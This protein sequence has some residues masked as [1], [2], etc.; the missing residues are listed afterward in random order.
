MLLAAVICVLLAGAS[1]WIVNQGSLPEHLRTVIAREL[2]EA[3]G[4]PVSVDEVDIGIRRVVLHGVHVEIGHAGVCKE[5][6]R[7]LDVVELAKVGQAPLEALRWVE[8]EGLRARLP[9]GIVPWS[10]ASAADMDKPAPEVTTNRVSASGQAPSVPLDVAAL[11]EQLPDDR[12]VVFRLKNAR[13]RRRY[14][15]VRPNR[16]RLLWR[17]VPTVTKKMRAAPS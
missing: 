8:V 1:L 17:P 3:L 6:R 9:E 10:V 13:L 15:A 11:L 5:H 16:R 4:V 14:Q 12:E 2:T 7:R